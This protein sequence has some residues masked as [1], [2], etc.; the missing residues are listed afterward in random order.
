MKIKFLRD[1]GG[2]KAGTVHNLTPW[3]AANFLRMRAARRVCDT[4]GQAPPNIDDH[5]CSKQMAPALNRMMP[6]QETR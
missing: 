6:R 5:N 1:A 3:A 2:K 4:C